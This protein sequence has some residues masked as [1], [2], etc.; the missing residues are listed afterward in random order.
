[1]TS[2]QLCIGRKQTG[3]ACVFSAVAIVERL[4]RPMIQLLS[5]VP[6]VQFLN[7]RRRLAHLRRLRGGRG[8]ICVAACEIGPANNLEFQA[9]QIADSRIITR[10]DL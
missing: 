5:V 10:L 2:R 6:Y 3:E 7:W 8:T 1:M 4:N 9:L